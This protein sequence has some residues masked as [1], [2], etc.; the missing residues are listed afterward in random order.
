[1]R[2]LSLI[3]ALVLCPVAAA[4]VFWIQPATQRPAAN[5]PVRVELRVGDTFPGEGVARNESRIEKFI[6]NGPGGEW[7]VLGRD[8]LEPAGVA[9]FT[10]P[11][12]Y[13]LGY[14]SLPSSVELDAAKF[15]K[16]LH[17]KG[18]ERIIEERA[19]A[20]TSGMPAREQYCRCAK[21]VLFVG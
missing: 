13:V 17:E 1:M 3:L 7:A 19:A 5:T 10:E 11:G 9:R 4:H 14:T 12:A 21:T 20:G 2:V 8:G 18:L 15:E 6:A 16:Y